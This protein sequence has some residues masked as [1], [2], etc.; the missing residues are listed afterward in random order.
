MRMRCISNYTWE[1]CL[2][3]GKVYDVKI[4]EDR[5]G[6][7]MHYLKDDNNEPLN[8]LLGLF[9]SEDGEYDKVTT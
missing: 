8:T 7:K 3:I 1:H 5:Y 6:N 2:T 9:M 4:V